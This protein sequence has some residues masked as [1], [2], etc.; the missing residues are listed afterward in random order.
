[1]RGELTGGI[2]ER[3]EELI[4]FNKE[5]LPNNRDGLS[6]ITCAYEEG[7]ISGQISALLVVRN[8]RIGEIAR[9]VADAEES[10]RSAGPSPD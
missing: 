2:E 1:M 4:A 8:L 9:S 3:L 5:R 6:P 7:F 10:R